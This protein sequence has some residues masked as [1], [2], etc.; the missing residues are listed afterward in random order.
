M[1]Q[2]VRK[3]LKKYVPVSDFATMLLN[4]RKTQKS[5]KFCKK[6]FFFS[7]KIFFFKKIFKNFQKKF[8]QKFSKFF[9]FKNVQK[10][11]FQKFSFFLIFKWTLRIF[12]P[13]RTG[14]ESR[15]PNF[16]RHLDSLGMHSNE[17]FI[18]T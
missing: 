2:R 9:L 6:N 11:F 3:I 4:L 10:N 7:K 5:E 16:F 12:D 18:I 1:C 15:T 8:C 14:D 13:T 17:S